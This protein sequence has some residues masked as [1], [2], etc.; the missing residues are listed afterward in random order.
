LRE[1]AVHAERAESLHANTS[2]PFDGAHCC[3][4]F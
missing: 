3:I 4:I 2:D 1:C